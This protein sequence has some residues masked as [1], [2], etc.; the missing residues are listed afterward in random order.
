MMDVTKEDLWGTKYQDTPKWRNKKTNLALF[1]DAIMKHK[2]MTIVVLC[3][4]I[5]MITNVILI[6]SFVKILGNM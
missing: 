6:Y 1:K 5:C 2:I 4:S 3:F